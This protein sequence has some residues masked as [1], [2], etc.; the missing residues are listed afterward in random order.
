MIQTELSEKSE[1]KE[2]GF[3]YQ[4]LRSSSFFENL[5]KKTK[6]QFSILRLKTTITD[7]QTLNKQTDVKLK[8]CRSAN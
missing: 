5:I 8:K 6:E 3:C 7:V 2:C 4:N 1:N